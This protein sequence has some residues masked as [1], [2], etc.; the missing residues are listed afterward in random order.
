MAIVTTVATAYRWRLEE[1]LRA[2]EANVFVGRT[3]LIDG[4]VW[5]VPIGTWHGDTAAKV[6]RALPDG[7]Y[8]VTTSSLPTG[9]SLPDPDCWVRAKAADPVRQLSERLFEW[10]ASDVVL[11]VEIADETLEQD[12]GA[13][14]VLYARAGYP[15]YWVV[16][17]DG[18]YEHEE[19]TEVGYRVRHLRRPGESL[20]VDYAG[21][22]V[23]V[24]DLVAGD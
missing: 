8:V 11:V 15:R 20:V 6:L 18:V 13:K 5:S 16:T 21:T 12:L 10:N 1:F 14:A 19:P 9:G 22:Q 23:A 4:E 3:E 17:R 24:D 7:G 2:W